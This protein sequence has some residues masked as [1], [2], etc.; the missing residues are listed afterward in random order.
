MDVALGCLAILIGLLVAILVALPFAGSPTKQGVDL[1]IFVVA[2]LFALL[3]IGTVGALVAALRRIQRLKEV[4]DADRVAWQMHIRRTNDAQA[5]IRNTNIDGLQVAKLE[6]RELNRRLD[7]QAVHIE[8][9]LQSANAASR[10]ARDALEK[11]W[12]IAGNGAPTATPANAV[13]DQRQTMMRPPPGHAA[14]SGPTSEGSKVAVAPTAVHAAPS[15][16]SARLA[17]ADLLPEADEDHDGPNSRTLPGVGIE[18]FKRGRKAPSPAAGRRQVGAPLAYGPDG[19]PLAPRPNRPADAEGDET[20]IFV[21]L[22]HMAAPAA[23]HRAPA[24]VKPRAPQAGDLPRLEIAEQ[25]VD[26]KPKEEDRSTDVDG[27]TMLGV[28]PEALTWE[29]AVAARG[30]TA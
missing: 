8:H 20:G 12:K 13:S 5:V 6:T 11:A 19:R 22:A 4:V 2:C 24:E 16:R 14:A 15:E 29:K 7:D 3:L 17:A 25:S 30:S 21:P 10:L 28:G 9:A 23:P 26:E 18:H 1:M 27:R